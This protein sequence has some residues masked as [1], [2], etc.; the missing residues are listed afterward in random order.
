MKGG[1]SPTA[2]A[3]AVA[4]VQPGYGNSAPLQLD[5]DPILAGGEEG[6]AKIEA[7][8]RGHFA[9]GGTLIN[10]NIVNRQQILEAHKDPSKYPN[11]IVRV[12]GFSAYFASLSKDLRQ[13]IVDRIVA[14]D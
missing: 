3:V 11:L 6:L 13:L 4:S 10:M 8:I 5:I 14:E 9:L 7:L 2:L 1:G 12:T